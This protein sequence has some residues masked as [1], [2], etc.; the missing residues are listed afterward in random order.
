MAAKSVLRTARIG[1]DY[2][3]PVWAKRKLRFVLAD[4]RKVRLSPHCEQ[5]GCALHEYASTGRHTRSTRG[6][7]PRQ[8]SRKSESTV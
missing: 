5:L 4:A 1:V 2:A 8:E 3:G 7:A 6:A